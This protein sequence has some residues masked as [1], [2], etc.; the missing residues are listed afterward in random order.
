MAKPA[1]R[2]MQQFNAI[3]LSSGYG[4][5]PLRFLS[6]VDRLLSAKIK[7]P[8]NPEKTVDDVFTKVEEDLEQAMTEAE[9]GSDEYEFYDLQ[10]MVLGSLKKKLLTKT[11]LKN[12]DED[13]P[14]KSYY[15][16]LKSYYHHT[17]TNRQLDNVRP[18]ILRLMSAMAH[19]PFDDLSDIK[20]G[21]VVFATALTLK[22]ASDLMGKKVGG[23]ITCNDPADGHLRAIA[24]QH[25]IPC[26]T[27]ISS[28]DFIRE[29]NDGH[30]A[31][32]DT[33]A[34]KLII[35]PDFTTIRRY[36]TLMKAEE[37]RRKELESHA[38]EPCET[39]DGHYISILANVNDLDFDK[40]RSFP[41]DGIG[42][43][44]LEMIFARHAAPIGTHDQTL[45]FSEAFTK[46]GP[47]RPVTVRVLDVNTSDKHPDEILHGAQ[48]DNVKGAGEL[49]GLA[50]L[51]KNRPLLANQYRSLIETS[52]EHPVKILLPAVESLKQFNDAKKLFG[53]IF[54]DMQ[55]DGTAPIGVR[56]PQLGAMIELANLAG[57]K[58]ALRKV[59]R[60]S[61]FISVG[62]NDLTHEMANTDRFAQPTLKHQDIEYNPRFIRTLREIS[63]MCLEDDKEMSMCGNL[64]SNV[65]FLPLVLALRMKPV[66]LTEQIYDVRERIA[67]LDLAE[68]DGLLD[69][70]CK[71]S[72]ANQI[73][74]E[75]HRFN[76]DVLKRH[77][78]K[79]A[80]KK[81][82]SR[83]A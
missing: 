73:R 44:R 71:L 45:M 15:D 63:K 12:I 60:G 36:R 43:V 29:K 42:L 23:I 20:Q 81:I 1:K 24:L 26:I 80:D 18:T 61:D 82:A 83:P 69:R 35:D 2:L 57:N 48:R 53:Y 56:R 28:D 74:D 31:I 16:I 9:E 64:A 59:I 19:I 33:A 68:C 55:Q 79:T 7:D 30:N 65:E 11:L 14:N 77:A 6:T 25:G 27:G 51:L 67:M 66:V 4:I 22:Q 62:T 10:I 38:L 13:G 3:G 46:L 21:D 37:K 8:K 70:V 40:T 49:E 47:D 54:A 58:T 50:F 17:T 41:V 5:G 34:A 75:V 76:A 52:G 72:A 32:I 39:K 78:D